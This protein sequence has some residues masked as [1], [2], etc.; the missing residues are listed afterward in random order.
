MISN[1]P[2]G[3]K[4]VWIYPDNC[5]FSGR[6][7]NCPYFSRRLSIFPTVSELSGFFRMIVNFL[8]GF[9]TVRI[10]TDDCQFSKWFQKCKDFSISL[11]I[12]R[13]ISKLSLLFQRS[14]AC[15]SSGKPKVRFVHAITAGGSVRFLPAV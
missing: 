13:M 12:F 3:F 4:T 10:F 7:Q 6:F 5:L 14:M 15:A 11:P 8:D 2:D 1:F 9:E